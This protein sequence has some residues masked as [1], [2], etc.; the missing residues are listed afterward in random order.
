MK[1]TKVE[2]SDLI[3]RWQLRKHGFVRPDGT[4]V[5]TSTEMAGVL[6]YAADGSMSVLITKKPKPQDL[7]DLINYAGYFT[8]DD[9]GIY[10][11]IELS[12]DS[13]RIGKKEHR[14]PHLDKD[15]LTLTNVPSSEG[16]YEIVWQRISVY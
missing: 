8:I 6:I 10:H 15:L 1:Q 7:V 9:T 12:P 4:F 16:H 3:G 13:N 5:P 11:H 14:I 2:R